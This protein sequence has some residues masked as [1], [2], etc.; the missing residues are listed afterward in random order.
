MPARVVIP[1]EVLSKIVDAYQQGVPI[2]KL[3]SQ[4]G[5]GE[6]TITRTLTNLGVH[7]ISPRQFHL[8]T[9]KEEEVRR[10]YQSGSKL[11]VIA[12]SYGVGK[13]VLSHF[14]KKNDIKIHPLGNDAK[15][16]EGLILGDYESGM[17]IS[18]IAKKY[19]VCAKKTVRRLL[20]N[21]NIVPRT[22]SENSKIAHATKK[23]RGSKLAPRRYNIDENFL[24]QI[25][26]EAKAYFLGFF[27]ADGYNDQKRGE[28]SI[29]LN[30]KDRAILELFRTFFGNTRAV[31]DSK[32][33]SVKF[34]MKS[35]KLS[36]RLAELGCPQRKSFILTFPEWI[37][38]NLL[39]HFLRGYTDGDGYV[40]CRSK[41]TGIGAIGS[42]A[43]IDAMARII[44]KKCSVFCSFQPHNISKGMLNFRVSGTQQVKR[45]VQFLYKDATYF[46]E[47]KKLNADAIIAKRVINMQL[48][49]GEL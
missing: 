16:R 14:I 40:M 18:E 3:I 49:L 5:Y 39:H 30:Q 7:Q 10:L 48:F 36:D 4:F 21:A 47:R 12:K 33:G 22:A 44:S 20:V 15:E 37:D 28:L 1:E 25:D 26:S 27:Y 29:E 38:E 9:G 45:V 2:I 19:R 34:R 46:L 24:D 13:C 41:R 42:D 43:F 23:K 17:G 11:A 32:P 6:K 35:R 31:W 8:L